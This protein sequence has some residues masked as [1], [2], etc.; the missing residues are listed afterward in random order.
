M[1]A[2]LIAALL[3]TGCSSEERDAAIQIVNRE[4]R[5]AKTAQYGRLYHLKPQRG[6]DCID[7]TF[8]RVTDHSMMRA[9]AL[10]ENRGD[11]LVFKEFDEGNTCDELPHW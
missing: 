3:L 1:S 2:S 5:N 10:L 6:Y 8:E 4:I 9:A 11:Y 7:V